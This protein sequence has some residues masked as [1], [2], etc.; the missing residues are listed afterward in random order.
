M[1]MK[2][3]AEQ[4][5]P[6]EKMIWQGPMNLTD[7]ELIAILLG[8]GT[9]SKTALD[10]AKEILSLGKNNLKELSLLRP[11]DFMKLKGVGRAKS[12]TLAAAL[13]LGRRC[14]TAAPLARGT[15]RNSQDLADFLKPMLQDLTHE[16]FLIVFLNNANRIRHY[17]VISEGGLTATVADP[18]I[19]MKKALEEN[20]VSLVLC[21]NHPSGNLHP[22]QSDQELTLKIREAARLFDIRVLDHL[23]VSQEGHYS[24][25]DE[26]LL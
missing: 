13:E 10:L 8:Q 16:V 12:V 14:Q 17:E 9:R 2:N 3:W 7:S 5:R 26:G 24:F 11:A 20:A 18:R 4:D 1:S 25:A 23:I 15:I 22:S 19:I 6:R 21:H